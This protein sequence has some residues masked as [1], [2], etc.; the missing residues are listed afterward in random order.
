MN[1]L[2]EQLQNIGRLVSFLGTPDVIGS[3]ERF[4]EV[5][6]GETTYLLDTLYKMKRKYEK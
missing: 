6:I 4:L 5:I 3:E 2:K 1:D